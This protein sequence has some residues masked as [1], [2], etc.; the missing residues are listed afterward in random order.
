MKEIFY[1]KYD[2]TS[3]SSKREVYSMNTK[4]GFILTMDMLQKYDSLRRSET[5][6]LNFITND[7]TIV[8]DRV[9]VLNSGLYNRYRNELK[10]RDLSE[11]PCDKSI[12]NDILS[13]YKQGLIY[14]VEKGVYKFSFKYIMPAN[15]YH[16]AEDVKF[17]LELP[18]INHIKNTEN[19]AK[20]KLIIIS[21]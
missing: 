6:L 17:E 10:K 4:A 5:K 8:R 21:N 20:E 16:R 15:I 14:R 7:N 11:G 3:G 12:K 18:Y 1:S 19:A 9:I 13:L 2:K